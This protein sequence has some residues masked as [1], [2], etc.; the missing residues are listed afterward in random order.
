[1]VNTLNVTMGIS[2]FAGGDISLGWIITVVIFFLTLLLVWLI[3]K[4]FKSL[5]Y[6]SVISFCLL[7]VYWFSRWIGTS[8]AL[9]HDFNPIT[10]FCYALA[11]L[12]ISICIGEFLQKIGY[13]EKIKDWLNSS[14]IEDK[15]KGKK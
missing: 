15:S 13:V 7:C 14:L 2:S 6:G 1:M 8:T 9:D 11:F 3:F 5:I 12:V 4:K 10:V